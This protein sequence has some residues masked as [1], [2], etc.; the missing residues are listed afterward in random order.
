MDN[1]CHSS[2]PHIKR[3]GFPG[4]CLADGGHGLR[5]TDFVSSFPS[6]IHVGARYIKPYLYSTGKYLLLSTIAGIA[7]LRIIEEPPWGPSSRRRAST[8]FSGPSLG[9]WDA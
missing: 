5:A 9:L 8:F 6:G 4:L 7:T 1:G 2:I 3:L